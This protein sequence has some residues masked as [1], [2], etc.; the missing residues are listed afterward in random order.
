M[1]LYNFNPDI[2]FRDEP[3]DDEFANSDIVRENLL[4][5]SARGYNG[6]T[7]KENL[8]KDWQINTRHLVRCVRCGGYITMPN[9]KFYNYDETRVMCYSC[10]QTISL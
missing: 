6:K 3:I 4:R 2:N 5:L 9:F 7:M 1:A 10:Q 8:I